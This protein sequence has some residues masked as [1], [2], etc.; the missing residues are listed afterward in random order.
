MCVD[1]IALR[2]AYL[3][4]EE[5]EESVR[6]RKRWKKLERRGLIPD[7]VELSCG[8]EVDPELLTAVRVRSLFIFLM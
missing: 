8:G 6:R 3:L 1:K 7:G 2:S 4:E 5:G